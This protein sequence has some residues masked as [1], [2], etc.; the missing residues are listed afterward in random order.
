MMTRLI[1]EKRRCNIP[2][3]Q[4]FFDEITERLTIECPNTH[5]L[6]F[7]EA[8]RR[9]HS[10]RSPFVDIVYCEGCGNVIRDEEEHLNRIN[11]IY[12]HH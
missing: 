7:V 3:M 5:S 9:A 12:Y 2:H 10:E 4:Y 8:I 6:A 11:R 1:L